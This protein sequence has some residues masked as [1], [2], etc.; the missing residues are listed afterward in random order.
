MNM[1]VEKEGGWTVIRLDGDLDAA[2][3]AEVQTG[4]VNWLNETASFYLLDLGR[5]HHLDSAGL[6]ALVKFYREVR[7]RGGRLALCGVQREPLRVFQL[8]R[9]DKIF[10]IYPTPDAARAH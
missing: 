5:V 4:F 1:R 10:S 3:A 2:S 8:T 6:A 7:L 9:L